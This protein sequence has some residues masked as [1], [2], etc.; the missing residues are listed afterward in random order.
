VHGLAQ[1]TVTDLGAGRDAGAQDAPVADDTGT[2]NDATNPG[3]AA[4][5]TGVKV[6]YA[7]V[8]HMVDLSTLTQ[9]SSDAGTAYVLLSDIVLAALPG[10][11]LATVQ[12]GFLG[13]GGFD[14]STRPSCASLIPV[15]GTN[16]SKGFVDPATFNLTWDASLSYPGCL[17]V[18]GLVQLTVT[19]VAVGSDA[20]IQ[21]TAVAGD[22]GTTNDA[23][24][25]GDAVAQT[26][27][28]V[29]YLSVDHLVDLSTL[30]QQTSDAGTHYVLLSDIVLAALPGKDLTT[31]Q[32]GF[33]GAGGFD[34]STRPSCAS[35][36]PV[37][38]TNFTK[39]FVDPGTFYL[40]WDASLSYPGC[41]NVHGLVQLTLT[42]K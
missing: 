28:K 30:T 42:D 2:A 1:V 15:A 7:G 21:D 23:S 6:T 38:G 37:A 16:F 36:I 4:A 33:L 14:P 19:D 11:N 34:P 9:Q 13:T 5:Q 10:K 20:G 18:H 3:D 22:T 41:L 32:T 12:T 24:N 29:T 25:P 31:V 27:V 17:S 35:L 39:G 40:T 26:G 8:D